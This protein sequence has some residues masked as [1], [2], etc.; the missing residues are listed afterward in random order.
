MRRAESGVGGS[1]AAAE[2]GGPVGDGRDCRSR[3][4]GCKSVGQRE[5]EGRRKRAGR[6]ECNIA[7]TRRGGNGYFGDVRS[8]AG[9]SDKGP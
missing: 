8:R 7:E 6:V 3:D 4:G 2:A 5:I 1:D 9:Y